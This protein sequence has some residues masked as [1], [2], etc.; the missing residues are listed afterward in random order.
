[1]STTAEHARRELEL[2][3]E[4]EDV[5]Q[6]VER[7]ANVYEENALPAYPNVIEMITKILKHENLTPL[8]NNPAEWND[9]TE[10]SGTPLWQSARNPRAFSSNGGK[11]YWIVGE[12]SPRRI[13]T[14]NEYYEIPTPEIVEDNGA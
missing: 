6:W 1:M 14:S 7:I 4:D 5:I 8:T 2:I 13:Y 10:I 12:K 11:G 3:G 9:R